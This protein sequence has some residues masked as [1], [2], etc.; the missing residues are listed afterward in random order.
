MSLESIHLNDDDSK[1]VQAARAELEALDALDADGVADE[2]LW[3]LTDLAQ[4]YAPDN[5][6]VGMHDGDG[7]DFGV[8]PCEE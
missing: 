5:A 4:D 3:E 7:A 8:W 6:T 1:K 2:I